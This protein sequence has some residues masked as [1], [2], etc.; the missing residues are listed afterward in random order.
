MCE[1]PP[2]EIAGGPIIAKRMFTNYDMERLTVMCDKKICSSKHA[3]VRLLE[4]EHI[5]IDDYKLADLRPKR[6]FNLIW[7]DLNCMRI[8]KI[9]SSARKLLKRKNI[10][11]IFTTPWRCEFAIAAYLLSCEAGLPLYIFAA[12]DWEAINPS[13][14]HG[15]LVRRYHKRLLNHAAKIWVIS[16][17]MAKRYKERFGVDGDFLINFVNLNEYK[18]DNTCFAKSDEINIVYTGAVLYSFVKDAIEFA[19]KAIN[20]GIKI[21]GRQVKATFYTPNDISYLLGP[22]VSSKGF[23][24]MKNIPKILMSA[25]ML[26]LGVSFSKNRNTMNYVKNAVYT[27]GIEYLASGKPLLI[28]S[29]NYSGNVEYF[30]DV[31]TL[32]TTLDKNMLVT[33][34]RKIVE[35]H[36]YSN[37]LCK[38]G[39][40]LV[41]ERHSSG[42][43]YPQFLQFFDKDYQA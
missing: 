39:L 23:V 28:V 15:Y 5:M 38:K 27:K 9:L 14:I 3:N 31:A 1:Y 40:D 20:S 11:A 30:K 17:T 24:D 25:D 4:C 29:P 16:P 41:R 7:Y 8:F 21:D 32:V 19:C 42:Q 33:A 43:I 26:L 34:I 36:D 22:H 10:E 2:S 35:D 13:S 18:R 6:I 12:D 37:K